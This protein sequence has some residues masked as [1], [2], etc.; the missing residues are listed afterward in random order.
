MFSGLEGEHRE[1]L[2]Q[3]IGTRDT[4]ELAL[5]PCINIGPTIYI[6]SATG[7]YYTNNCLFA[8]PE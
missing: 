3:I 8:R 7:D 5:D 2:M 6:R 1:L 4:D